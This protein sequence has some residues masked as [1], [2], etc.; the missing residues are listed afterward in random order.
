MATLAIPNT[1][2]A[3]ETIVAADV[4]ENFTSLETILNTTKLDHDN[5]NFA[6]QDIVVGPFH[7]S[8]TIN[9]SAVFV[10]W[11]PLISTGTMS[12]LQLTVACRAMVD[13][14][15]LT[16]KISKNPSTISDPDT[17]TSILNSSLVYPETSSNTLGVT[18]DFKSAATSDFSTGDV[19]IIEVEETGSENVSD[20]CVTLQAV[21]KHRA[22]P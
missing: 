16:I 4:N 1:F 9:D 21:L 5:L 10:A 17:G 6:Y 2:V 18:T 7:F 15:S 14:S 20:I 19:M 8:G 13:N 11:K 22:T 3:G 12:P